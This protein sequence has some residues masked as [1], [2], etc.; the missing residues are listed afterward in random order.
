M[1]PLTNDHRAMVGVAAVEAAAE[2]L[3]IL[4][5]E[6]DG[7]WTNEVDDVMVTAIQD[8][9][10]GIAHCCNRFGLNADECFKDALKRHSNNVHLRAPARTVADGDYVTLAQARNIAT[11][12]TPMESIE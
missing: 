12:P 1:T 5:S 2:R 11:R 9:L 10:V 7:G 3:D 4:L 6:Y 8:T